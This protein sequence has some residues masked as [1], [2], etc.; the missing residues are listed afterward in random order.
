MTTVGCVVLTMGTRPDGLARALDSVLAQRGVDLD[1]VVVGNG[2][3]PVGLPDG[4]RP[5]AL[6]ENLGAA[7]GRNAGVPHVTGGFV[8]F[9]DDDAALVGDDFLLRA[10]TLMSDEIGRASCR[11]RV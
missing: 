5:V 6:P 8:L 2:W 7:G 4:V 11:E 3:E 10:V 9:L 1:V